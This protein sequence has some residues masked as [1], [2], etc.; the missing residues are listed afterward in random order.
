MAYIPPNSTIQ[1]FKNIKLTPKSEDTA[2]FDNKSVQDTFFGQHIYASYDNNSYTRLKQNTIKLSGVIANLYNCN[3]MRFKNT[4][5]ENKWIYAFITRVDYVNNE[6]VEIDYIIDD[7]QTWL[8]SPD[9][10]FEQCY[11][12]RQHDRYDNLLENFIPENL[13]IGE[14]ITADTET[15]ALQSDRGLNIGMLVSTYPNGTRISGGL[16]YGVFTGLGMYGGNLSST[17]TRINSYTDP[18]N[19]VLIFMYPAVAGDIS[20]DSGSEAPYLLQDTFDTNPDF[21]RL[22]TYTPRNNKLYT[23]PYYFVRIYSAGQERDY[24]WENWNKGIGV[25]VGQF[26]IQLTC[27]PPVTSGCAPYRYK[28]EVEPYDEMLTVSN[29]PQCAWNEDAYKAWY[30]QHKA[31]YVASLNTSMLTILGGELQTLGAWGVGGSIVG[32]ANNLWQTIALNQDKQRTP[33]TVHGAGISDALNAATAQYDFTAKKMC[34]KP[35]VAARIDDFFDLYGYKQNKIAY[36]DLTARQNWTYIKT[37]GCGM[38]GDLPAEC[39]K[40]ICDRFDNGIRFWK[41]PLRIGDYSMSNSPSGPES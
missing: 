9:V 15:Y 31:S 32:G 17:I 34:V 26:R 20:I 1:L 37:V 12:E 11:I 21:T 29:F 10:T 19:I 30:A 7:I 33:P 14:L 28:G 13:E 23:F 3:Y 25:T 5:F 8:F 39:N 6:T 35:E 22:G 38:H 24:R 27:M 41:N 16:A 18:T 36:P 2:Y 40:N 4:S